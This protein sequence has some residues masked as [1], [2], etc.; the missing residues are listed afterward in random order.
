MQSISGQCL[1][2]ALR[3]WGLF[4]RLCFRACSWGPCCPWGACPPVLWRGGVF[5]LV[6]PRDLAWLSPYFGPGLPTLGESPNRASA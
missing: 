5:L 4:F 6:G 2:L 3:V 1:S